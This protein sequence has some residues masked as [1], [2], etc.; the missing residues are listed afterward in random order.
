MRAKGTGRHASNAIPQPV[1]IIVRQTVRAGGSGA[2]VSRQNTRVGC[3]RRRRRHAA[4]RAAACQGTAA[5]AGRAV[6]SS[7]RHGGGCVCGFCDACGACASSHAACPPPHC[8]SPLLPPRRRRRRRRC[9]S[10]C[11]RGAAAFAA[12]A[13]AAGLPPPR[14]PGRHGHPP[15]AHRLAARACRPAP[16]SLLP[17]PSSSSFC[18]GGR[19]RRRLGA[20][21]VRAGRARGRGCGGTG[22]W[23]RFEGST[24]HPAKVGVPAWEAA[25][26]RDWGWGSN[27]GKFKPSRLLHVSFSSIYSRR[28][29]L[30]LRPHRTMRC[31]RDAPGSAGAVSWQ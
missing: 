28:L 16:P 6:P 15:P 5:T 23:R 9:R 22:Q 7:W 27:P 20:A 25:E 12:C 1:N 30:G 4:A 31:S 18:W 13:A 3:C 19:A 14:R 2:D 10:G 26:S 24:P 29:A 11:A 17:C 21:A 8:S